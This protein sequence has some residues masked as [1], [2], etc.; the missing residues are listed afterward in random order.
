MMKGDDIENVSYLFQIDLI[1][2]DPKVFGN[3]NRLNARCIF[4][5]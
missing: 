1:V 5:N 2:I 3:G 4:Y